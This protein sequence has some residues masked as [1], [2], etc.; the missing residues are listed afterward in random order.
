MF[1]GI[2]QE[3]GTIQKISKKGEIFIIEI[4]ASLHK[5]KKIG[6]SISID[7][8]CFTLTEVGESTFTIEAMTE[9]QEKTIIKNYEIG[10]SVNLESSLKV[11]GSL[12]GHFVSGHVD[13]I[14][15]VMKILDGVITLEIPPDKKKFFALKGS[16]TINGV[17]LTI[18]DITQNSLSVS[19][20][21]AT[22]E[23]TNLSM[24]KEGK[25][26]NIEIDL[27]SRYLDSL[28][29]GKEKEASYEF[30]KERGFL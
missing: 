9:T 13:F 23:K 2:I 12:D 1:T 8:A 17:S 27:I 15:K 20:I 25:T 21:P 16:V 3:I 24:L 22:L 28:L 29:Q 30:L 19:L 11:G 26:V 14:S 5:G 10:T 18:S 4:S 7:G 6:A